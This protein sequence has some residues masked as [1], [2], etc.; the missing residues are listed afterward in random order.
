MDQE[1]GLLFE[2]YYTRYYSQVYK[3]ILKRVT[4]IQIA[5]DLTMNSFVSCWEKFEN[6]DQQK[7]SFQTWLYVVVNN[8]LK[9]Y[10][11]DKKELVDLEDN[12]VDGFDHQDELAMSMQLDFL[13]NHLAL[14]LNEL[15]ETQRKI[16]VYKYF[17]EKNSNEIAILLGFTPGNVRVQLKRA[18]DKLKEYFK[19]NNIRWE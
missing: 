11:R 17:Q 10:Y 9:N 16:V 4:N 1:K 19:R 5:E 13:R 3:Y 12:L 6:F 8:K 15:P 14:A 18:I 7:A 2:E